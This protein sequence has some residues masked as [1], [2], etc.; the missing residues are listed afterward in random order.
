[1]NSL[2]DRNLELEHERDVYFQSIKG[3]NNYAKISPKEFLTILKHRE[4]E[5]NYLKNQMRVKQDEIAFLESNKL[6]S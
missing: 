3:D 5:L 4:E 1:M 6:D 2:N